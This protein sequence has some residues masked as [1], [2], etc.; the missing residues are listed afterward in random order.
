[1]VKE[2]RNVLQGPDLEHQGLNKLQ[3]SELGGP[4]RH[5]SLEV[6]EGIVDL[7][8]GHQCDRGVDR[9]VDPWGRR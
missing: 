2:H 9:R 6:V 4:V 3:P 8:L 5:Q 1:V 7:V